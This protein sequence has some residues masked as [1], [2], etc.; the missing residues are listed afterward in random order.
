MVKEGHDN[1]PQLRSNNY[2]NNYVCGGGGR[3]EAYQL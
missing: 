1:A 3:V 2:C